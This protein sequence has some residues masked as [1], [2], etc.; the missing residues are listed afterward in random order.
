MPYRAVSWYGLLIMKWRCWWR[1][2]IAHVKQSSAESTR[3][4]NQR[5]S[6]MTIANRDKIVPKIKVLSPIHCPEWWTLGLRTRF[7]PKDLRRF[8]LRGSQFSGNL[9]YILIG[10]FT[11]MGTKVSDS[12]YV[13][14]VQVGCV[15]S[16]EYDGLGKRPAF[17]NFFHRMM[18]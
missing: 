10:F 7:W 17:L 6:G 4:K 16:S 9:R 12:L 2:V 8:R 18:G 5:F 11:Q 14:R 15:N 1:E 3:L 13:A